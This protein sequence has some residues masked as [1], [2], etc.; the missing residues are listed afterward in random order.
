MSSGT[1]DSKAGCAGSSVGAAGDLRQVFWREQ[2]EPV[3]VDSC[4]WVWMFVLSN[5]EL[6]TSHVCWE[7]VYSQ[8]GDMMTELGEL[9]QRILAAQ[10]RIRHNIVRTPVLRSAQSQHTRA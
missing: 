5:C 6:G 2:R 4:T 7:S 8:C 3:L 1:L 9:H 10:A